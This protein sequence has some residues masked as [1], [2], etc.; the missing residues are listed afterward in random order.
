MYGNCDFHHKPKQKSLDL[1]PDLRR[2]FE[3]LTE[4]PEG[5][6][7]YDLLKK[8][9][10]DAPL[11]G[12]DELGLFRIHF[13]LFHD[14]HRLKIALEHKGAGSLKIQCMKIQI[15]LPLRGVPNPENLPESPDPIAEYYLDNSVLHKTTSEHVKS[16]LTWFWKRFNVEGLKE[17]ALA[18]LDLHSK[19]TS[20]EIKRRYRELVIKH[21]PDMGG[22]A[23]EF[24]KIVEAMEILR[25]HHETPLQ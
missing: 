8:L 18:V 22:D 9:K 1:P 24:H 15:I 10:G 25:L 19:A 4:A 5:L 13:R 7:E 21:H 11:R 6:S 12:L 2:L 16:L 17:E 23:E 3:I 14:L 20:V